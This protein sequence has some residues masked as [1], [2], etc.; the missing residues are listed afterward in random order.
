MQRY[1]WVLIILGVALMGFLK[2]WVFGKMRDKKR[3]EA[4]ARKKRNE[5][6]ENHQD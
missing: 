6:N 2:L 4:E 3:Q 5:E 1:W